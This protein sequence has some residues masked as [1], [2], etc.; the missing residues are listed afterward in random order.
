MLPSAPLSAFHRWLLDCGSTQA[1]AIVLH[2]QDGAVLSGP[3]ASYLNEYDEES[4]GHWFAPPAA[5]IHRLSLDAGHRRLLGIE[6]ECKRCPGG[7]L[8]MLKKT[9]RALASRGRIVLDTPL[10]HQ[11]SLD[12]P[13]VFHA[14]IGNYSGPEPDGFDVVINPRGFRE[15]SVAG[16]VGDVFLEWAAAHA[17]AP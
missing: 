1:C 3:V 6:E 11:A 5:L 12:L 13:N 16:L 7:S 14:A 9:L 8:C 15:G 4:R 2:Q 17:P 10:S